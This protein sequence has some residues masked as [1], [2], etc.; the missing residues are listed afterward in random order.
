MHFKPTTPDDDFGSIDQFGRVLFDYGLVPFELSSALLMV[1]VLGAVAVAKGKDSNPVDFREAI[2]RRTLARQ[3]A[4]LPS[5]AKA[6]APS[7]SEGASA[8]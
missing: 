5:H 6:E 2:R 7:G 1:A 3:A 8:T 4:P